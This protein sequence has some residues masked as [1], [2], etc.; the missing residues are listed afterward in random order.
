[1][2]RVATDLGDLQFGVLLD[3]V[4]LG[5]VVLEEH[6]AKEHLL[7]RVVALGGLGR[8]GAAVLED[9]LVLLGAPPV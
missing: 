7:E 9:Q 3:L 5:S 6:R 1:M 4:Q 8:V 2:A